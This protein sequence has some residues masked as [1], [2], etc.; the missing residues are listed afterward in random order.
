MYIQKENRVQDAY[1]L[2]TFYGTS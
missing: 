1:E 2:G